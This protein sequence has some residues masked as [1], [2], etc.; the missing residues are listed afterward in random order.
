M[1]LRI[2]ICGL[3][4]VHTLKAAIDGGADMIGLVF[5][6][7]SPRYVELSLAADLADEA[8][9]HAEIVALV[10]DADDRTLDAIYEA[11]EPDV[12]QLHGAETP[13]R[14]IDI[15]KRHPG[16]RTL[17]AIGVCTAGDLKR[18]G[19]YE[20]AADGILLD[21]M[22]PKGAAY[23]GGHGRSF[24]WSILAALD[25]GLPFMLSGGLTPENVAEA[26]TTVR[27]R[28]LNLI[29]VDVSSGV[30]RSPGQKS[31]EKIEAFI[32]AAR[33]A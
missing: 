33:R 28:K 24:D 25:P 26:I 20:A 5:H 29:G 6:P 16:T 12:W 9:G 10:T 30:E 27:L 32:K 31:I 21:A 1:Q 19:P 11:V 13:T 15:A 22:P 7:K 8:R 17:K 3:S 14:V 18:I 23:P 2:K 4:T